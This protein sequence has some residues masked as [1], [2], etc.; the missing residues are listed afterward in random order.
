MTQLR[1]SKF[2]PPEASEADI[3]SL[4]SAPLI[5]AS[6]ANSAMARDQAKFLMEFCFKQDG[7]SYTPVMVQL[8][9]YQS[10][11]EPGKSKE[12]APS[13]R[14]ITSTFEVPLM[15]MIPINSLA[16]ET[17]DLEFDLEISSQIDQEEKDTGTKNLQSKLHGPQT[18]TKLKGKISYDS[19]ETANQSSSNQYRS[20][21]SAKLKVNVHAGQ[22]PLPVGVNIMIDLYSK[23]IHPLVQED[24]SNEKNTNS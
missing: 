24:K 13:I 18:S 12:D 2:R 19:K 23:S 21:N 8:H 6:N 16:V 17:V 1:T 20:Q 11:L 10:V 22:L 7:D 9:L 5:A 15:T 3:G 14:R 4:I